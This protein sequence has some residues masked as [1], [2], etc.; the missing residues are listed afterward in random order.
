MMQALRG[1]RAKMSGRLLLSQW[2]GNFVLMLLAAA[3]LQIPDSHTWQFAFSMLS[4]VLLVVGFLL[5]YTATFH[6]LRPC[7][8]PAPRWLSWVLLA[9][10]IALWWLMLQAIAVGRAHEALY[11]GYWNSQS[12]PWLRHSLGYS[13]LVAWQERFYDCLQC[14]WAGLLLPMAIVLCASGIHKGCLRHGAA[15]YKHWFYWLSVLVCGLGWLGDHLGSRRLDTG[16]GP[17]G[18]N[19][20]RH[21]PAR[22]CLHGG[23]PAVVLPAGACRLL[24]R[25]LADA[26]VRAGKHRMKAGKYIWVVALISA[27]FVL[28]VDGQENPVAGN[29]AAIREGA[30]LFRANCSPCHGLNAQGGGRGPDLTAGRWVHGSS[31]ADIFRTITRGVPGTEMPANGFEDSETWAIL[32]YL[33][34]LAPAK[35]ATIAGDSAKGEK[36]FWGTGG[37]STCHMVQ[38]RGGVLGPDLSRVG[39]ARSVPYLV[40]SIREPSKELTSGVLDPNN[41]YGLPLVYDTVTVVTADGRKIVG[42]AKN[43]DTFSVQLIDTNQQLQFFLKKNVKEVIHERKSLMPA[44]SETMLKPA[45]LQDLVAYLEGLRD[46]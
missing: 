35:S 44:Y 10:F 9:G 27:A 26:K 21:C 1:A 6:H 37:C 18:A 30:S 32:A 5:L 29:P 2:V 3:W 20:Q 8:E 39:E 12:P 11:A 7:A 17:G 34:S 23:H 19:V 28:V 13:S 14:L 43:E 16:C 25:N 15:P 22:A 36:I 33:R 42:I 41:H 46:K 24:S 4:G 40:D 45:E 31:D 38:G